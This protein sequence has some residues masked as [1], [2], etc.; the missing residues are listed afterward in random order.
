MLD[1]WAHLHV[2]VET[3]FTPYHAVFYSAMLTGAIVLTATALRNR[4]LGYTGANLLPPAYRFA[5][6]GIPVFFLGGV[7][8]LIWHSVFGVEDRVDAVT[9]PTHL[10]IGLG[11]FIVTSAPIRSALEARDEL[12]SLRDLLPVIF[13][14]ATWLEFIHLGTAYA[15]DPSAARMYAPPN[16]TLYSPDLFTNTTLFLFKTGAGV[17]IVIFQTLMIMSFA[18]WMASNF[19]L[20]AGAMPLFFLLGNC[21]IAAALTNDTPLFVTYVAM[22]VAAGIAGDAVVARSPVQPLRSRS[23]HL[24]GFVVP[25]VYY[26]TYFLVTIATGGMWWG[27]SLIGGALVWAGVAGLGLTLLVRT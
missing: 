14:L 1:S 16:S 23:L 3:F 20:R 19:R 24:F 8:D 4:S 5:L 25:V 17:A 21:I 13:S 7:G 22:S 15:F 2:A 12:R 27:P 11:V 6:W 10:I 18:I 26:A 9:S